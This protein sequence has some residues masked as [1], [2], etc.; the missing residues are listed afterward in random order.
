MFLF[1]YQMAYSLVPLFSFSSGHIP[2]AFLTYSLIMSLWLQLKRSML[3]DDYWVSHRKVQNLL[4][5]DTKPCGEEFFQ[6][7]GSFYLDT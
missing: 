1:M 4:L 6:T 3:L 2:N 7:L 5:D